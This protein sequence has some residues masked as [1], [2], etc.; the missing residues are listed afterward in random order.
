MYTNINMKK[1]ARYDKYDKNK[2]NKE[3]KTIINTLRCLNEQNNPD[4]MGRLQQH[5]AFEESENVKR[6]I[7]SMGSTCFPNIHFVL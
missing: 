1:K 7:P 5:Y 3:S 2:I 6:H 4:K